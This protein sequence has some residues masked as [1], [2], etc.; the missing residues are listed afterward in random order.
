M[1]V[2]MGFILFACKPVTQLEVIKPAAISLPDHINTLAI[3]DRSKPSSGFVDVLEG[4][5][6]GEVIHQ[7]RNGRLRALEALAQTLTRTP[8]FKVVNTGL[9]LTGS[10]TGST[11]NIPLPW[12]EIEDICR[13]YGA[14]AVIAI[15]KFDSDN[16][17]EVTPRKKKVKDKEGNEKE[18]TVYDAKQEVEV[19]LGWRLYDPKSR[20]IIDE[21]EVTDSGSDSRSDKSTREEAVKDLEDPRN[22]TYRVSGLAGS[23]YAERIAPVWTTVS[24][25]FYKKAKGRQ[26]EA[27]A[28]AARFFETDNW[29]GA[30]EIWQ[31]VV[32][33]P[34]ST[35]E[36]K[37]MASYNMAVAFEKR[38]LL[39]TALQWAQQ[40]YG[41]YGN[42]KAR[43]YVNTLKNRLQDQEILEQQLKDRT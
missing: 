31:N 34:A 16:F 41:E 15:E 26:E 20:S 21:V 2:L 4:G 30:A 32:S 14:D 3:I 28:R 9:A 29:E 10:E 35:D 39:T 42:K 27:M 36:V 6:T 17:L 13:Q 18:E 12:D 25:T 33:D 24:R 37:G 7:D 11:F 5:V 22:I 40:S 1:T 38:G 23:Q 43:N 19:H 8:R